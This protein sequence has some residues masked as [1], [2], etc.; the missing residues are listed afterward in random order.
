MSNSSESSNNIIVREINHD[1]NE[2]LKQ[3][4][5][6]RVICR[7]FRG[8]ITLE[9]FPNGWKDELD[10]KSHHIGAIQDNMVIAAGRLTILQDIRDHPYFPAMQ[11]FLPK[12]FCNFPIAYLSRDQVHKEYRGLGLRSELLRRR[13]QMCM[14]EKVNNLFIDLEKSRSTNFYNDGYREVGILDTSKIKW[15]IQETTYILMHKRLF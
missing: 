2:L 8:D 6:L 12:Q 13:E 7:D 14:G 10:E 3:I 1:E 11:Y 4:Y 15:D 5:L 9:K